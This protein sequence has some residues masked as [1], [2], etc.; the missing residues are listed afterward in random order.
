VIA[1]ELLRARTSLA[2]D[3]VRTGELISSKDS[4]S[5]SLSLSLSSFGSH[6]ALFA[7]GVGYGDVVSATEEGGEL[8]FRAV[9]ERSGHTTGRVALY[10]PEYGAEAKAAVHQLGCDTEDS[11]LPSLFSVDIPPS[12]DFDA[13]IRVL[14]QG[15]NE[16]RWDFEIANPS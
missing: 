4:L 3:D 15:H 13:V 9:L 5:L 11:H 1:L 10:S 6:L 14:E 7:Y 2:F 16:D 12:V 8:R